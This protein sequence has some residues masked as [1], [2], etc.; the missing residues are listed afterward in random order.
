MT[1]Y[2]SVGVRT[3]L[4]SVKDLI[5]ALLDPSRHAHLNGL[6]GMVRALRESR[7][8]LYGDLSLLFTPLFV[9]FAEPFALQCRFLAL[10]S[11]RGPYLKC[12][13]KCYNDG[14]NIGL[15]G[16]PYFRQQSA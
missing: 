7:I 14:R 10:G 16:R 4:H 11:H 2:F 8:H 6:T 1:A 15:A 12:S 9:S 3:I 5:E 13:T